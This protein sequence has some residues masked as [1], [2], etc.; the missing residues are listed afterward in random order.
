MFVTH[1]L[2]PVKIFLRYLLN[3][4]MRPLIL[5][6]VVVYIYYREVKEHVQNTLN[7]FELVKETPKTC[8]GEIFKYF[9]EK[10]RN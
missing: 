6:K 4:S 9:N 3:T 1:V 7:S 2:I 5:Q 8:K 10:P